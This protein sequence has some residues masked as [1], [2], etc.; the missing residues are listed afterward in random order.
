MVLLFFSYIS[1]CYKNDQNIVMQKERTENCVIPS[2][3]INRSGNIRSLLE[4]MQYFWDNVCQNNSFNVHRV[5]SNKKVK[6]KS[7]NW[8]IYKIYK[9]LTSR[10]ISL[11]HT[12]HHVYHLKLS[13]RVNI[14]KQMTNQAKPKHQSGLG[15]KICLKICS[16]LRWCMH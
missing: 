1:V 16:Q 4:G 14:D 7:E 15:R 5:L 8:L 13:N 2:I 12:F 6:D 10:S 9:L 11:H 3:R